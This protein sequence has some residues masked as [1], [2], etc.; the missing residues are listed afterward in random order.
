MEA[1]VSVSVAVY[2]RPCLHLT[3]N[4][5]ATASYNSFSSWWAVKPRNT[6]YRI[7][8]CEASSHF[9]FLKKFK[10]TETG[11]CGPWYFVSFDGDGIISAAVRVSRGSTVTGEAMFWIQ[12]TKTKSDEPSSIPARDAILSTPQIQNHTTSCIS[13]ILVCI[14]Q[15]KNW[16]DTATIWIPCFQPTPRMLTTSLVAHVHTAECTISSKIF[17]D[18]AC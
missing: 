17:S 16:F 13:Y 5:A 2:Y 3:R 1:R 10:E 4:I 7:L 9:A 14:V 12:R 15:A 18:K 6:I 8:L 11:K